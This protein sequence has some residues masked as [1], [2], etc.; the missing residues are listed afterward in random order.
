M[1][2]TRT[3]DPVLALKNKLSVSVGRTDDIITLSLSA[4]T[5]D[6]AAKVVNAVV[7]AYIAAQSQ[8]TR[9]TSSEILKVLQVEKTKQDELLTARLAVV[10]EFR[11]TNGL[12]SLESSQGN[13]V[14][15]R[16]AQFSESLTAAQLASIH[17]KAAY[18]AAKE[19]LD[20][21]NATS[22]QNNQALA[23]ILLAQGRDLPKNDQAL[24]QAELKLATLKKT[25]TSEHPAVQAAEA[26]VT[27]LRNQRDAAQAG[28]A[29]GTAEGY[30]SALQQQSVAA[31]NRE[32][33]IQ[34]VYDAQLKLAMDL[35]S[36][37]AEYAWL[38]SELKR[39]EHLCEQLDS[40]IKELS[41]TGE[42]GALNVTVLESARPESAL[43]SPS[44]VR[45]LGLAALIGLVAGVGLALVRSGL[46]GQ[47]HSADGVRDA[48]DLPVL[49]SVPHCTWGRDN[50]GALVEGD[51]NSA[52]A[53]SFRKI[54]TALRYGTQTG[55]R[56][57]VVTSPRIGEGKTM[58]AGNLAVALACSGLRV[59]LID[60]DLRSP[61]QHGR[62]GLDNAVGLSSALRGA[63]ETKDAIRA[64]TIVG[65]D[66]IPSGPVPSSPAELLTNIGRV[67]KDL[68]DQY[69]YIVIDTP[70]IGPVTDAAVV[71]TVSDRVVLVLRA[72]TSERE[73]SHDAVDALRQVGAHLAGVVF[74]GV[75]QT[76]G[77]YGYARGS[78]HR[79]RKAAAKS[80]RA[81]TAYSKTAQAKSG[82]NNE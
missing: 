40:R 25:F 82:A 49:G 42:V 39:T 32:T 9:S 80:A 55:G 37:S 11:K 56:V 12:L 34:N 74:N 58:V 65:L 51:P 17:A 47:I 79:S 48:L 33:E 13:V 63:C 8:Q 38:Q 10:S 28:T 64:S 41:V 66:V 76:G 81:A 71:A 72:G 69:D 27:Q 22:A 43:P 7:D 14:L 16:L 78:T 53:E 5:T 23:G 1:G 70:P 50:L 4:P 2:P 29:E 26:T 21:P 59:L 52:L 24:E 77:H 62:F 73:Q 44:P 20:H 35:N 61:C 54:R 36:K 6:G 67:I 57:I 68:A 46:D 15:Q 30:L 3:T 60:A 19:V 45:V 75:R 18:T 31:A